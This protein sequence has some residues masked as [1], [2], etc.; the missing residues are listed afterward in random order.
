[1]LAPSSSS[2]EPTVLGL[3]RGRLIVSCQAPDDSPMRETA[4]IARLARAAVQGGAGALRINGVDDITAVRAETTLP[5]IGLIK[6]RGR[7]RNVITPSDEQVRQLQAAGADLIAIDATVEAAGEVGARVRSAT[8][9]S[10]VPILADVSDF[11][12]GM[13]AWDA[14]AQVVATTLSGYTPYSRQDPSPDLELIRRLADA[15]VRVIAEGR[16]TT[17]GEVAEAFSAGALAVVVGSAITD[18]VSITRRFA[19]AAP[20]R[21]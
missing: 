7:R 9:V 10:T 16:F 12:E 3:I 1:M 4:T 6:E 11:A 21:R 20:A 18:P 15:G 13:D 8:R 17:P 5:L 14:G 19:A 2:E